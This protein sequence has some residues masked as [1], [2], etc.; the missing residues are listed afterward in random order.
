MTTIREAEVSDALAIRDIYAPVV[1]TSAIS[2]ES[3]AP[4]TAEMAERI[5]AV[6]RV[7]PW[8]V[9]DDGG[10]VVAYAYG[11]RHRVR[12]AYRWS[13]EVSAYVAA[14][15]R[16]QGHARRLYQAL[17][18]LLG[19]QG[20]VMLFAGI[21][22]PNPASV[23]LH[24][25]VGFQPVGVYPNVGFKNGAWHDVGWWSR[26]AGP[27]PASPAAPRSLDDIRALPAYATLLA[28]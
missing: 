2:F 12:D 4:T 14:D 20:Y 26:A 5:V 23:R 28:G 1:E 21:T 19:L 11:G 13:A 8:L 24:E 10:R 22:L 15:A 9:I 17:F 18:G 3:R 27:L 7:A 25:S 6:Q 16:R